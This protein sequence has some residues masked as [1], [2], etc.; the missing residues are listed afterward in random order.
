VRASGWAGWGPNTQHPTPNTPAAY[1]AMLLL[2]LF[3]AWPGLDAPLLWDDLHL[4]RP[5]SAAELAATWHGPWDPDRVETPGFRPLTTYFNHARASLLGDAMPA[6]RLL[7]VALLG[8]DALLLG[9]LA[10]TLVGAPRAVGPV[11]GLLAFTSLPNTA[12]YLWVADGVHSLAGVLV[13]AALVGLA[14]RTPA[15]ECTPSATQR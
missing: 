7:L 10:E 14:T 1:L 3:V 13:A 15:R 2:F 8:L 9:R 5:Y 6:H 4:I 11:A 12:N